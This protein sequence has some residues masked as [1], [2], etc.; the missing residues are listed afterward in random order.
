MKILTF[1][2]VVAL[3]AIGGVAYVHRQRG[4]DWSLAS[5]KDTLGYLWSSA[6]RM[7]APAKRDVQ[8]TLDRA[9]GVS[10]SAARGASED[11][12]ARPYGEYKRNDDTGRH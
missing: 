2:R 10:G 3:T 5:I 8:D 11:R 4:G 12:K 9:A 6:G 1:K 7:L